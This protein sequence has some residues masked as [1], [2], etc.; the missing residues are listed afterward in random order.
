[1][2]M[3]SVRTDQIFVLLSRHNNNLISLILQNVDGKVQF[4]FKKVAVVEKFFDIIY[5]VH[6]ESSS[7]DTPHL[8]GRAG[9]HCGQKRTYRAVS[10]GLGCVGFI[11]ALLPTFVDTKT[12]PVSN[13]GRIIISIHPPPTSYMGQHYG[14]L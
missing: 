11:L 13:V 10:L 14:T 8:R 2:R 6:V 1:M 7:E 5:S 3:F 9:K 12:G 4:V